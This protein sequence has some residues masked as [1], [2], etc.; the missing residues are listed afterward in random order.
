MALL[1]NIPVLIFLLSVLIV[2]AIACLVLAVLHW[3]K[4][5][6]V[7]VL[8]D[9]CSFVECVVLSVVLCPLIFK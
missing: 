3:K 5:K 2:L 7:M 6:P 1:S 8:S 9:L 4:N